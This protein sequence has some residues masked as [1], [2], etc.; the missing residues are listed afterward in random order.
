MSLPDLLRALPFL[1]LAAVTPLDAATP[2]RPNVLLIC[3]DD[4]KPLLGC[5][6]VAG[7]RT[8]NLDRLAARGVRFDRA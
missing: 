4:L 6:G 3:V 5:Y 1:A 2:S 8:P 7:V